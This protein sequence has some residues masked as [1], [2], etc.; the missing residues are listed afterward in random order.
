MENT[1]AIRKNSVRL[2]TVLFY[3]VLCLA[4]MPQSAMAAGQPRLN[5]T[6]VTIRAGKSKTLKVKNYKKKYVQWRS[7][8]TYVAK[9]S[10]KGVVKGKHGGYAV[11]FAQCGDT[12]LTCRVYV[13]PKKKEKPFIFCYEADREGKTVETGNTYNLAVMNGYYQNWK[14][15]VGNTEYATF[16]DNG[17]HVSSTVRAGKYCQLVETFM[18]KSGTVQI[19]AQSGSTVLYFNLVIHPA[20]QDYTYTRMRSQVQSKVLRSNMPAQEKCLAIAKWLSD[21]AT[22]AI[23]NADDYSLFTTR[24]GQCYHYARSYDFLMDGTGIPCEY[25]CTKA[26]AWNQVLIDGSWF[27]IDVTSFDT[28]RSNPRYNFRHFMIS[29]RVFWRTDPRCQ[30]YHACVNRRYDFNQYYSYSPWVTGQ[31]RNY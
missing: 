1:V 20:A 27:N 6:N 30:P 29:D 8:N 17:S 22:Y 13:A 18:G 19:T 24:K 16:Y 26:H 5:K 28:D 14:W 12:V 9:V 21:Y 2:M 11:I 23:T 31:W 10:K 7:S 4:F 15:T 3:L 25:V